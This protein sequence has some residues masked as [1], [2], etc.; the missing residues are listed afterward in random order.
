MKKLILIAALFAATTATAQMSTRPIADETFTEVTKSS[1]KVECSNEKIQ[2]LIL[3]KYDSVLQRYS[4]YYKKDRIGRYR[5]VIF[6]F[7]LDNKEEVENYLSK[8]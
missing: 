2:S 1:F 5:E 3:G 7:P 6:Y 4:V 8:L